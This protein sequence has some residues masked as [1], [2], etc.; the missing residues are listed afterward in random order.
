M[1]SCFTA[2]AVLPTLHMAIALHLSLDYKRQARD[3]QACEVQ[4][5]HKKMRSVKFYGFKLSLG[6]NLLLEFST[7]QAGD[8][9]L[10]S[11]LATF[12]VIFR[13]RFVIELADYNALQHLLVMKGYDDVEK[14]IRDFLGI[15]EKIWMF[16]NDPWACKSIAS[17]HVNVG[18]V[19]RHFQMVL[20]FG[21][22]KAV[23]THHLHRLHPDQMKVVRSQDVTFVDEKCHDS[24]DFEVI[25][26]LKFLMDHLLIAAK[27]NFVHIEFSRVGQHLKQM[28]EDKRAGEFVAVWSFSVGASELHT[29][30]ISNRNIAGILDS[31]SASFV[32]MVTECEFTFR[33]RSEV[34]DHIIFILGIFSID[35]PGE[36]HSMK[37]Q[38]F[39]EALNLM[40]DALP[41]PVISLLTE[42]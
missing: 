30:R 18:I 33:N 11:N 24:T 25:F 41:R 36:L 34:I 42:K 17:L 2:K 3:L 38:H 39:Y 23:F 8:W 27:A 9:S 20:D 1:W 26:P 12:S 6:L 15:D 35:I 19:H 10:L 32:T 7:I 5:R 31:L 28:E 22:L 21:K 14:Q 29:F 4:D 40:M 13:T 37:D 16:L